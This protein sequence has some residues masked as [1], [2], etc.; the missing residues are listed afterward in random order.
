[1]PQKNKTVQEILNPLSDIIKQ[2]RY[3]KRLSI[4][5]FGAKCGISEV[6]VGNIERGIIPDNI[7]FKTIIDIVNACELPV[8]KLF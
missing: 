7:R 5:E 3:D 1:M 8:K 4:P 6:T 2:Y